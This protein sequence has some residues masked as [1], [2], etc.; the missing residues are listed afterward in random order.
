MTL[1]FPSVSVSIFIDTDTARNF[2]SK[3]KPHNHAGKKSKRIFY[4]MTKPREPVARSATSRRARFAQIAH[5]EREVTMTTLQRIAYYIGL[6]SDNEAAVDEVRTKLLRTF[7]R[8]TPEEKLDISRCHQKYYSPDGSDPDRDALLMLRSEH[9]AKYNLATLM[10]AIE[11]Q[12]QT[13]YLRRKVSQRN[14]EISR[15]KHRRRVFK[16]KK[17]TYKDRIRGLLTEIDVLRTQDKLS[18]NEIAV[19]LKR[20]HRKYFDGYQISGSYLRRAY[21][22]LM[23]KLPPDRSKT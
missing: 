12:A 13:A 10:L 8:A 14:I 18:W 11:D 20:N 22:E 16:V 23:E 2:A 9:K 17:Q 15:S 3:Y 19:F 7:A 1:C 6:K 21:N 4:N 5:E